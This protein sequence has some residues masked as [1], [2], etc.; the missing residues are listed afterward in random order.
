[1]SA[2]APLFRA[3]VR[4]WTSCSKRALKQIQKQNLDEASELSLSITPRCTSIP[5]ASAS[6]SSQRVCSPLA[7]LHRHTKV[8]AYAP[9]RFSALTKP[10][11]SRASSRNYYTYLRLIQPTSK[12]QY[13]PI[14]VRSSPGS[15]SQRLLSTHTCPSPSTCEFP[16]V[17]YASLVCSRVAYHIISERH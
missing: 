8:G 14:Y 9:P 15:S 3:A 17:R 10:L 16:R 5:P 2:L 7:S 11:C 12:T 13:A 6:L 1:M 4:G